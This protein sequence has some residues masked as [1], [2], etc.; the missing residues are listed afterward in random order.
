MNYRNTILIVDDEEDMLETCKIILEPL[1]FEVFTTTSPQRALEY[2]KSKNI[3]ILVTDLRMPEMNGLELIERA[4][5]LS[6]DTE[7]LVFTAY[8]SIETAVEAIK[9]GAF[10]YIQKPFPKEQFIEL[11]KR[12][13]ETKNIYTEYNRLKD[14]LRATVF[15]EIIYSSRTMENV[16]NLALKA[17][18]SDANVL[19]TGESGTGK[20]MVAKFIHQKS[21]RK[22][23]AFVVVDMNTIN[24]SIAESEL[25]GYKKGAF[26]GALE[27]RQ[28]LIEYANRGTLFIDEIGDITKTLQSKLLRVIEEKKFR[29]VG[30][31][32][33]VFV[34]VRIISATNKD[35]PSM[36]KKGE[37][38]EDLYYRLNVI[39][40]H[41]P[42]LRDRKEDIPPLIDFLINGFNKI[43]GK[44]IKKLNQPALLKLLA[45]SWPGNVRE[46]KNVLER[47][48]V[49]T[50]NDIINEED[51]I[52]EDSRTSLSSGENQQTFDRKQF[53]KNMDKEYLW[54]L[55]QKHNGNISAAAREAGVDRST[56]YRVLKKAGS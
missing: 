15:N 56:I 55:V 11:I 24:E 13:L 23:E 3:D 8:A 35:I 10:N 25:F 1:E 41:I 28:G 29:K 48:V 34:D 51:I 40:L 4:K 39:H 52:L 20:E 44:S 7:I 17:S 46:L 54:Q 45:Y 14:S 21:K 53:L 42:P 37:F 26:T 43:Y 32:D 12:A 9:R 47:A 6:P 16:V 30:G 5:R 31:G 50:N 19:I 27:N 49:L 38:R 33:E 36:I 22:N 18:A 2:L